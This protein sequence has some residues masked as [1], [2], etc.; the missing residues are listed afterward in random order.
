MQIWLNGFRQA[1]LPYEMVI[2][3]GLIVIQLFVLAFLIYHLM[4]LRKAKKVFNNLISG[5]EGGSLEQVFVQLGQRVK[6]VEDGL[7]NLEQSVEKQQE[8]GELHIQRWSLLRYKAFSNTGGDQSFSL[9][10]LDG[11]GNGVVL[12]SIYGRDESRMYAKSINEGQSTYPMST[13][14]NDALQQALGK[15]KK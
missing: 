14:E 11:K 4:T 12:S 13:E 5:V 9:A 15:I 1:L 7:M 8:I 2:I 6:N 10:L 3:L